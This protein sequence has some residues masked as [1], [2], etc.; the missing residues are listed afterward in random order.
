MTTPTLLFGLQIAGVEYTLR[1]GGYVV[2]F[3]NRSTIATV[4][5][6]EGLFLPGGGVENS[7]VP[8]AAA[9]RETLEECGLQ[10][11]TRSF[12]C[13]VDEFVFCAEEAIHYRKRCSFFLA[14]LSGAVSGREPEFE[15]EW[16]QLSEAV[17][18]LTHEGH[19]HAVRSAI[20]S[21]SS[22]RTHF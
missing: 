7:E 21:H 9:A 22:T 14:E 1:P 5:S 11:R 10:I 12:L 8:E 13:C 20:A 17:A 16:I 15:L 19:R 3:G 18:W 6:P 4:R 2:I